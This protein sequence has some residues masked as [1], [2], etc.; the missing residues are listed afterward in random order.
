[1]TRLPDISKDALTPKQMEVWEKI[2]ETRGTVSG[3]YGILLRMPHLAELMAALGDYFRDES[4]L[5]GADRELAI[6]AA[7]REIGSPYEWAR[8]EAL[9]R[10][11]GA[12][13]EAIESL[14][15]MSFNKLTQREL[16]I[17]EVVQSLF[18]T[19]IVPQLLFD[20]ALREL[21]ENRLVEL[22][23]L[24]GFYC[25]IAFIIMAFEVALP[26]DVE[27]PF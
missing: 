20:K 17:V 27:A 8:H 24:S 7:A 19:K 16:I 26:A 12:R 14:R 22:V 1:M 11:E 18:R 23:T 9:A 25:S 15:L 10:K 21:G 3:P 2:S 4:V 6:L 5:S 13:S